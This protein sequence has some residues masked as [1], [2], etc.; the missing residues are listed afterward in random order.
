VRRALD[1]APTVQVGIRSLS[2][3]EMDF[4]KTRRHPVFFEMDGM[5]GEDWIE[6]MISHLS[7][8]IYITL[9]LDVLNPAIMPSVGTPEPGGLGWNELLNI[10]RQVAKNR[11]IV[12][13]DV[14]ELCPIPGMLAPDFLAARL[15]YKMI[16]YS[17]FLK[18][19][20]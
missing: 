14:M 10:V 16:G 13:F 20:D 18:G 15:V 19:K 9:D 5:K 3:E 1:Y 8:N 6:E 4:I 12:G 11:K 7:Q 17:L 2:K